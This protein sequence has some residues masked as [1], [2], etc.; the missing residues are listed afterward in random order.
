[1]SASVSVVAPVVRQHN[2]RLAALSEDL[3]LQVLASGRRLCDVDDARNKPAVVVA[4]AKWWHDRFRWGP[5]WNGRRRQGTKKLCILRQPQ[6]RGGFTGQVVWSVLAP[7]STC[8]AWFCIRSGP[9]R[10]RFLPSL[11]RCL[12]GCIGGVGCSRCFYPTWMAC[13]GRV[14]R[15]G[16]GILG[17]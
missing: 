6:T 9:R 16:R 13:W 12:S 5:R 14:A 11:R 1:M 7:C 15:C 10:C 2:T 4:V 17:P 8:S 3:P